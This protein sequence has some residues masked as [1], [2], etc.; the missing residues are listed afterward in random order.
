M[1]WCIVV[2]VRCEG[3]PHSVR[4]LNQDLT[5]DPSVQ[6]TTYTPAENSAGDTFPNSG[7]LRAPV[8]C[9]I[10]LLLSPAP[11]TFA[12]ELSSPWVASFGFLLT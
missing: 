3:H 8:L 5:Q 12:H 4:N 10:P 6:G 11:S 9:P 2:D 1:L 7:V